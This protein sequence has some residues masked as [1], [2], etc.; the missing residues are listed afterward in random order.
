MLF[1]NPNAGYYEYI[2]YQSEWLSYTNIGINVAI[3]NYRGYGRSQ[4]SPSP[5][6]IRKDGEYVI[7]HFKE[8]FVLTNKFGVHGQSL[9]GSVA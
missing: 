3:W 6:S 4:G 8:H 7:K 5:K 1:C 2:N 9:G